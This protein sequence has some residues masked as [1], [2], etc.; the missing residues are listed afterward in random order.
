MMKCG[1]A[2]REIGV[3]RARDVDESV[4]VRVFDDDARTVVGRRHMRSADR[5]TNG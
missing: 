2:E 3:V 1:C 5:G 4:T